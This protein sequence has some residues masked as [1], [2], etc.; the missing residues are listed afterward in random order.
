MPCAGPSCFRIESMAMVGGVVTGRSVNCV[1][2]KLGGSEHSENDKLRAG[3]TLGED[4]RLVVFDCFVDSSI[5]KM[6]NLP[7]QSVALGV[8]YCLLDCVVHKLNLHIRCIHMACT[9]EEPSGR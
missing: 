3:I 8:V 5:V 2:R 7:A 4:T 1:R 9:Y 6:N